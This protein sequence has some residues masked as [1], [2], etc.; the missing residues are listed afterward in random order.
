MNS[1]IQ[2]K[3]Q[4]KCHIHRPANSLKKLAGLPCLAIPRWVDQFC[5][6]I[7][8]RAIAII[9]PETKI[10]LVS[11]AGNDDT[12]C[13]QLLPKRCQQFIPKCVKYHYKVMLEAVDILSKTILLRKR[14]S[15]KE[16]HCSFV[17]TWKKVKLR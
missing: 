14:V 13:G 16:Y 7:I 11:V 8:A 5:C 17:A 2:F 10:I 4:F 1:L 6:C 9:N 12:K 3:E 15:L